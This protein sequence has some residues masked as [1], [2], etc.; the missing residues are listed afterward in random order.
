MNAFSG[1]PTESQKTTTLTCLLQICV[2]LN[3]CD[4]SVGVDAKYTGMHCFAFLN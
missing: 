1:R 4:G 3:F 2:S